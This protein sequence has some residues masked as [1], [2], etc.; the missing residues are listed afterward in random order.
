MA[1]ERPTASAIDSQDAKPIG[2]HV[3]RIMAR[4]ELHHANMKALGDDPSLALDEDFLAWAKANADALG[5]W[6]WA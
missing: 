2:I 5:Q 3:R 1:L 6:G 4:L